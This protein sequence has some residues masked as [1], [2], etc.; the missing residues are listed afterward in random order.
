MELAAYDLLARVAERVGDQET[1]DVARRIR[2]EENAMAIRLDGFWDRTVDASLDGK[3]PAEALDDYLADAHALEAQGS[4][5]SSARR[6]SSPAWP[7]TTWPSPS[8]TPS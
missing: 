1:A 8:A 6:A 5:C 2:E 4:S 7:T 3:D